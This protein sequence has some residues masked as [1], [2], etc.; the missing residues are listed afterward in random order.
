MCIGITWASC[1]NADSESVGLWGWNLHFQQVSRWCQ[2]CLS[3]YHTS[4]IEG[5]KENDGNIKHF[6]DES[7]IHSCL[8]PLD[9]WNYFSPC[10]KILPFSYS[11]SYLWIVLLKDLVPTKMKLQAGSLTD[12]LWCSQPG[13]EEHQAAEQAHLALPACVHTKP[14]L[15]PWAEDTVGP[16]KGH[17]EGAS[18]ARTTGSLEYAVK[19]SFESGSRKQDSAWSRAAN[20]SVYSVVPSDF[21]QNIN[22]KIDL[23]RIWR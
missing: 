16:R 4:N 11:L 20:L 9:C 22:S 2:S 18:V 17:W 23:L 1:K 6:Q 7:M 19:I 8:P 14:S 5:L 21:L 3:T 10:L 13:Q 15:L 12:A